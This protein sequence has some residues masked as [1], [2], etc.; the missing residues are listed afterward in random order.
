MKIYRYERPDGGGPFCTIDGKLR[1]NKNIT[2]NNNLLFGCSS[3]E[4]L[5]KWFENYQSLLYGCKIKIY[6]IPD[7]EVII[8]ED[9]V[10][11]P[12]GY[13]SIN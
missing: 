6:D 4:Q 8:G 11:F 1:I 9:E 5:F 7:S 10:L 3:I 13:T 12:K 2:Y